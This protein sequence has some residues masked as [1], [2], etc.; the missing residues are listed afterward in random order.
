MLQGVMESGWPS[1][2][3]ADFG[4]ENL[5]VKRLMEE[6]WGLNRGSFIQGPSTHNQRVERIHRDSRTS[7]TS[8]YSELFAYMESTGILDI[9]NMLDMYALHLVN[10]CS[11]NFASLNPIGRFIYH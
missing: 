10:I 4:G 9:N 3:R 1:R 8:L 5:G 6:K 7:V 11:V 2:V